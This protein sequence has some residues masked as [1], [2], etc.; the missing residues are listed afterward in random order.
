MASCL[1]YLEGSVEGSGGV[2]DPQK[3]QAVMKDLTRPRELSPA[4]RRHTKGGQAEE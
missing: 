1:V 2:L 4:G 3:R